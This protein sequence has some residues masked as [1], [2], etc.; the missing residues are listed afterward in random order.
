M[1]AV[2]LLFKSDGSCGGSFGFVS[3]R[4]QF[5]SPL[6]S[7]VA[8]GTVEVIPMP[9]PLK[10]KKIFGST[11]DELNPCSSCGIKPE[12][13]NGEF[14]LFYRC[15]ACQMRANSW[16]DEGAARESWNMMNGV[17]NA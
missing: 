12:I 9:L 17:S 16:A 6:E 8:S 15:P 4:Q 3:G 7:R 11:W 2:G 10:N 1:L 5:Q 14:G 13:I